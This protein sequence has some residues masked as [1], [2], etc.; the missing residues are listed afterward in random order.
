MQ[1]HNRITRQI[2]RLANW[3]IV[4]LS[5][6]L[7]ALALWGEWGGPGWLVWL[8]LF[9]VILNGLPIIWRAL[10]LLTVK[11]QISSALLITL[12]ML[13]SILIGE[14]FAAGEIALIMAIGDLLE[15]GT[16]SRAH[17][18]L[19]ELISLQPEQARLMSRD[20]KE[21]GGTLGRWIPCDE[22]RAGDLIRVK[23][24]EI[25]PADGTVQSGATSVDESILTGESL[26]VDKEIGAS[27]YTGSRN[28][29]GS[30]D[31]LVTHDASDSSLRKL[32]RIVSEAGQRQAPIH[33]EADRWARFLVP[34]SI[35]IALV[36][37]I[38]LRLMGYPEMEALTRAVTVLVV[39]CPCALVLATPT[40][41]MAA[42]GQ[43]TR[44]GVVIKSGEALEAL[45]RADMVAF[46]KTGTLTMGTPSVARVLTW[47]AQ[48]P[49]ELLA[50]AAAV[51][52]GSNHPLAAAIVAAA[53]APLPQAA[54]S[55]TSTGRGIQADIGGRSWFCGNEKA[56]EALGAEVTDKQRQELAAMRNEGMATVLVACDGTVMGA[57]GLRDMPRP[58]AAEV[59]AELPEE[60]LMLTGDHRQAADALARQLG[61]NRVESE[62]LPE[63]KSD[64]ILTLQEQGHKVVMVGDGINDAPALKAALVGVAMSKAGSDIATESADVVLMQNGL[65]RLPY[66][67]RLGRA[68]LG[69]IRFNLGLS[70][71]YNLLALSLSLMG[72]LGPATG[73]LAHNAG[74]LLVVLN[75]AA[76]FNR[77]FD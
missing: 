22:I 12:A 16:V 5:A 35:T 57:I 33:R 62:L 61:I 7:L 53:T 26:P 47:S 45:G 55:R 74:S 76:L 6:I 56:I 52:T 40:S 3:K 75:A 17:R 46:D 66:L 13:A 27:V 60:T 15:S 25:F 50:H 67:M 38:T 34:V 69:T 36:G 65:H 21:T 63:Q 71:C 10:T 68:T 70:V 9:S 1:L 4:G 2:D 11:K 32:I 73:A 20:G 31:I 8:S 41:I 49:D 51:E 59:L 48:N 18:G 19:K 29:D 77:K 39:F 54:N 30:V 64:A 28:G 72:I 42:I 58:E 23:P 14:Q 37:Y 44:R 43:A 24:G